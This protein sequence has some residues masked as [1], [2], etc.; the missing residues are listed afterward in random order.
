MAEARARDWESQQQTARDAENRR[1]QQEQE[2]AQ[3]LAN[4]NAW[5]GRA[6]TARG[7]AEQYGR[8]KLESYGLG[9][10]DQYGLFD[11]MMNTLNTNRSSLQDN[12][13]FSSVLGTN[14]IDNLINDVRSSKRNEFSRGIQGGLGQ[15]YLDD[16]FASTIDDSI[17]DNILGTQY[18]GARTDLTNALNRGQMNQTAYDRALSSLTDAKTAGRGKLETTGQSVIDS[19]RGGTKSVYDN[20]LSSANNF[21]FG[22]NFDL[23]GGIGRVKTS[24]QTGLGQLEGKVREAVGDTKYFDTNSLIAKSNAQGGVGTYTP[25]PGAGGAG[26][27]SLYQLFDDQQRNKR[28]EGAF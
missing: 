3:Q 12:Q 17:L 18:E 24:A 27:N 9:A 15:N 23:T 2:A 4:T 8:S 1:I 22:D 16:T 13:D 7:S 10:G 19:L 5:R 20:L 25:N 28:T 11:K 26:S 14:V 21:D 6:D